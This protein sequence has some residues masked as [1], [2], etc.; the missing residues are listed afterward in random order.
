M[1]E[2]RNI[3][4]T[5]GGLT[6]VD[7]VSF[8][9]ADTPIT[10][11]IG[12]NGS[13]KSTLFHC[14]SGFYGADRGELSLAGTP[15]TGL[16]PHKIS[17]LGI[18]RTFQ[19]AR[20]LPFMSVRDNLLAVAPGQSGERL[21]S[22]FFAPR[23]VRRQERALQGQADAILEFLRLD[24]LSGTPAGHLSYGQQKL[25]EIGRLLI[26]RPKVVLLDEP[27][28]GV[29]PALIK[30]ILKSIKELSR[31]GLQFFIIEHNMSVI[32]QLCSRVLVMDAGRLI[33]EGSLAQAQKSQRVIEAYL[34]T[35]T[36]AAYS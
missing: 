21:R 18:A 1:L 14:L 19:F 22:V 3:T 2:A 32:S 31:Q 28:A 35:G 12:P 13:G 23:A 26:A 36:H 10:G 16:A 33:F 8:A 24:P 30:Q 4:K 17:A 25:L 7:D 34:G 6:A 15:L 20:V 11:L 5:F 29:N 27:S 9:L